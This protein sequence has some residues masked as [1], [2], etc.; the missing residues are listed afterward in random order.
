MT[1]YDNHWIE[2]TNYQDYANI[3]NP[4]A[5]RYPIYTKDSALNFPQAEDYALR[6]LK[7]Y[8]KE[9]GAI[10]VIMYRITDERE[11]NALIT[12]MQRG[13]PVRVISDD[14]EYRFPSRQWVS[15]NLDKLYAAGVPLRVRGHAGFNHQKLVLFY[16]NTP[17]TGRSRR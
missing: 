7:R 4:P 16:N 15:Y 2:T 12:A 3:T 9:T 1:E 11:T 6:L 14:K 17:A 8:P 10:D 13:I 5:R